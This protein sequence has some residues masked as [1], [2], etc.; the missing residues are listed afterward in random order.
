M[1]DEGETCT[2]GVRKEETFVGELVGS[3]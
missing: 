1:I 2:E 3:G